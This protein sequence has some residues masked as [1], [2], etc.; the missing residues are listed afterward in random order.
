MYKLNLKDKFFNLLTTQYYFTKTC[1][2]SSLHP[3]T[4]TDIKKQ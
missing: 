3:K 1:K 4:V 2:W